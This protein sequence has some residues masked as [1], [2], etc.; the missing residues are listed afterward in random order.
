MITLTSLLFAMLIT[1]HPPIIIDNDSKE[2][3]CWRGNC[4]IEVWENGETST[5]CQAY[6]NPPAAKDGGWKKHAPKND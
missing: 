4:V 3:S 6:C 5:V 2:P 1:L